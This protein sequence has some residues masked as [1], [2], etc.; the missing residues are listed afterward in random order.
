MGSVVKLARFILCF[1]IMFYF[2]KYGIC[3]SYA[4]FKKAIGQQIAHR[5]HLTV[6]MDVKVFKLIMCM[7]CPLSIRLSNLY[8]WKI[9]LAKCR[10]PDLSGQKPQKCADE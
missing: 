6:L 10:Q 7:R 2:K 9:F 3:A 5:M 8:R 4:F 1:M